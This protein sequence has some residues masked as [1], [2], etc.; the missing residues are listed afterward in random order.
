MGITIALA[1]SLFIASLVTIVCLMRV[2]RGGEGGGQESGGRGGGRG[3]ED[4]L[5][6]R[7]GGVRDGERSGL[8]RV[9]EKAGMGGVGWRF[10]RWE[11]GVSN[12]GE[13]GTGGRGGERKREERK[14]EER[15]WE[16][17]QFW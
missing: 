10:W 17:N 8:G 5:R 12:G 11:K 4:W 13:A 16:E 7:G 14:R 3:L 1:V 2:R 9:E 15:G 6:R